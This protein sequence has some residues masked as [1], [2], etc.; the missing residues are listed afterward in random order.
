MLC[1]GA[2]GEWGYRAAPALTQG[3]LF[4]M[5]NIACRD[6][7]ETNLRF[8]EVFL[9]FRIEVDA[10]AIKNN[11][12]KASDFAKNYRK[13]LGSPEIRSC[14]DSVMFPQEIE[15][16]NYKRPS[17]CLAGNQARPSPHNSLT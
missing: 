7:L 9:G 4:S 14:R 11:V 1:T 3:A 8:A 15:N 13:L 17:W 16:L 5:A 10:S 2:Q 6:L 12:V